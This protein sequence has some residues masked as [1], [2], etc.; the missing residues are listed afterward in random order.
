[1]KNMPENCLGSMSAASI[2]Q[3]LIS[4]WVLKHVWTDGQFQIL[5]Q[6]PHTRVQPEIMEDPP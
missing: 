3:R 5:V 6:Q 2:F 4:L 1:M